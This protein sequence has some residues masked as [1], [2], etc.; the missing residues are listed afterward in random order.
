MLN[1]ENISCLRI[2]FN[3]VAEISVKV[4]FYFFYQIDLILVVNRL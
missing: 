2:V 4:L 3:V 1:N